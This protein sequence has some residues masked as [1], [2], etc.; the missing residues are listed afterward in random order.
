MSWAGPGRRGVRSFDVGC[1]ST[2]EVGGPQRSR[3]AV[4]EGCPSVTARAVAL[5]RSQLPRPSSPDGDPAA[6]QRLCATLPPL[7]AWW[8]WRRRRGHLA[9]RTAFFDQEV[10]DALAVGIE[11]VVVVGAGYDGRALRFRRPGVRF[12]ELDH[13]ATQADKR[14]RLEAVG[15]S[16]EGL[17]FAALD[18][19]REGSEAALASAGHRL[20]RPSLFYCE[21]LIG[22]LTRPAVVRLLGELRRRAAP[23]SRLALNAAE[24]SSAP[25]RWRP[26]AA[27]R[28]L[29]LAAIGEPRRTVFAPGELEAVLEST[30]WR[31]VRLERR[32]HAGRGARLL[33]AAEP[34]PGP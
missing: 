9:H 29:A 32:V 10:I 33:V 21:G 2:T 1:D 6:E 18:L 3:G 25:P 17:T 13:P 31:I 26:R 15:A 12:F 4:R 27:A 8:R 22:Y 16:L 19:M 14:R 28:R 24:A 7:P 20:D 30:G 23:G 11:Q 5:A 34:R